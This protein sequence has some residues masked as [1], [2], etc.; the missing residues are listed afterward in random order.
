MGRT[1]AEGGDRASELSHLSRMSFFWDGLTGG[2]SER[3]RLVTI[4]SLNAWNS[5]T[6]S[7]SHERRNIGCQAVLSH[8]RT[9]FIH[10]AVNAA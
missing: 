4:C 9:E 5:T 7:P 3:R 6:T 10:A 1:L 8:R 2:A